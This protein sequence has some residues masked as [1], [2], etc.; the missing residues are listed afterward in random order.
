MGVSGQHHA[1]AALYPRGK[2]PRYIKLLL[3]RYDETFVF[4]RSLL[5]NTLLCQASRLSVR[6]TPKLS[7]NS[8]LFEA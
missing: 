6:L 2:D 5:E 3:S 1:P 7:P 4:N 8:G